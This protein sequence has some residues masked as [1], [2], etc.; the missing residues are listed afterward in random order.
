MP[1]A[2]RIRAWAMIYHDEDSNACRNYGLNIVPDSWDRR[3]GVFLFFRK[4]PRKWFE[5]GF[6]EIAR[7][8]IPILDDLKGERDSICI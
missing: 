5:E 6:Q 1:V 2:G 3:F 8:W 7:L 4:P